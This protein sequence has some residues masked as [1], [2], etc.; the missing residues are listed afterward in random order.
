MLQEFKLAKS[1]CTRQV[2]THFKTAVYKIYILN[3][4][5]IKVD[6]LNAIQIVG[7]II[8]LNTIIIKINLT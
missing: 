1:S 2:N 4:V 3:T 5:L 7:V 6:F 8:I